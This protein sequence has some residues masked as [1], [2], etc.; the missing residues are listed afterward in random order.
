MPAYNHTE[1][2]PSPRSSI[3]PCHH[4]PRSD[5]AKSRK[6]DG[7]GVWG[8]GVDSGAVR[9]IGDVLRAA[10]RVAAAGGQEVWI[11]LTRVDSLMCIKLA[12]W[13]GGVSVRQ[14]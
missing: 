2:L 6:D 12:C 4:P 14:F 1:S 13:L 8:G 9:G 5:K 3:S 7:A 10:E 11:F